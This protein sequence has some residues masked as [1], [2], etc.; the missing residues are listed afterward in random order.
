VDPTLTTTIE[1]DADRLIGIFKDLHQT[2]E[3]GFMEVRTAGIVET[4]LRR[5]RSASLSLPLVGTAKPEHCERAQAEGKQFPYANHNP[6]YQVDLDAIP[7]GAKVGAA[8]V[9]AVFVRR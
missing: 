5:E 6:D 8:S 7:L 9:A 3:L 1:A 2:P 4:E